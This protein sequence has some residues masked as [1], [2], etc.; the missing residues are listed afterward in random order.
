ML[1]PL[2]SRSSHIPRWQL[3]KALAT[4]TFTFQHAREKREEVEEAKG[5]ANW[6][7]NDDSQELPHDIHLHIPLIKFSLMVHLGLWGLEM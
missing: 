1:V 5:S 4:T 7:L 3:Q 2:C 6:F